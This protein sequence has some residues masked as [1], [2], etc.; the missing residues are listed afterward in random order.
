MFLAVE[1]S[2]HDKELTDAPGSKR[3]G[4]GRAGSVR[5]SKTG[6]CLV[7]VIKSG[8]CCLCRR[9]KRGAKKLAVFLVKTMA[10]E[11]NPGSSYKQ[12]SRRGSTAAS[13]GTY[14]VPLISF[15]D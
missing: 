9:K 15:L 4:G 11:R 6:S 7:A 2:R 8:C 13:C 5:S 3:G 12:S 14:V 10:I 1:R